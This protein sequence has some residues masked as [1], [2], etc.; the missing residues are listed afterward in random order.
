MFKPTRTTTNHWG[1][2][3]NAT[4]HLLGGMHYLGLLRIARR[5]SGIRVYSA[6]EPAAVVR[7]APTR[8]AHIDALIDI[9]VRTYAP[10]PAA[11]L[12]ALVLRLRS[13]PS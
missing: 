7:D 9:I 4:T 1:G 3:S 2:S 13:K 6:Q 11:S 10:L 5:D 8:R 12:S